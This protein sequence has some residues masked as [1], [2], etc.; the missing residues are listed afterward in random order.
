MLLITLL[1]V[2]VQGGSPFFVQ[3]RIGRGCRRFHIIKFRTMTHDCGEKGELLPDEARTTW[4]GRLLRA[5]SL[6]ELPELINVL[7]GDMSFIGPRPWVPE[8]MNTFRPLTQQRRMRVRPG[9]SGLAQI[10]GRN[11]LTFRQR[12]CYDLYYI[13]HLTLLMD[14]QVLLYTFYKVVLR[15][16]IEQHPD[17]LKKTSPQLAPKD[18]MTKGRRGNSPVR[19]AASSV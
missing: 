2:A 5:T 18:P 13:R 4:L 10:R 12:V 15:E 7:K 6:D 19:H 11:D 3:Q 9:M 16:G 17:A 8:Q 14:V 1:L